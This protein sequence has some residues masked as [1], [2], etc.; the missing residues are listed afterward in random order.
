MLL[1]LLAG[2]AGARGRDPGLER[3][4]TARLAARSAEAVAAWRKATGAL[5]ARREREAEAGFREV[6]RLAPDFPDAL[7][8]LSYVVQG[9]DEALALARRA[10]KLEDTPV[11]LSALIRALLRKVQSSTG[12][13][14]ASEALALARQLVDREPDDPDAHTMMAEAA[15]TVQDRYLLERSVKALRRLA[16]DAMPTHYFAG[17]GAAMEEDWETAE[18]E[19]RRARQLGLP[20]EVADGILARIDDQTREWRYLKVIGFTAA[21]W[22]AGLVLLLLLGLVLSRMTLSAVERA[23]PEATAEPGG[24]VRVLRRVY[25]VVLAV[26]SLYFYV[27][28][29]M[30]LLLVLGAAGALFYAFWVI[31]RIPIKLVIIVA[32]GVL[33]TIWAM[34]K[35]PF[36]RRRDED[37]GQLLE[38]HAAPGLFAVLRDVAAKVG[39]RPVDAVYLVP[40]ATVAVLERGSLLRRMTG[41]SQRCLVLGLGVLEGMSD[42]QLKAILAHEYGHFS[43]KDTAGGDLALHVRTTIHGSAEAMAAGGAAAWYNPAWLFLN[44]FYRIYLRV[45]QGASRLQEVLADRWAAVT[46]GARAFADGLRHVIRRAITF[47]LQADREVSLAMNEDRPVRNL[48]R[49]TADELEPAPSTPGEGGEHYVP[50]TSVESLDEAI[51]LAYEEAMG[52]PGSAYDSHPAPRQ[53]IAW[54][55]RLQGAPDVPSDGAPAWSLMGDRELLEQA[56][57]AQVNEHLA[58]ARAYQEAV[59][60]QELQE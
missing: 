59:A 18:E 41:R 40:D 57:T 7:R 38:E 44:G 10:H 29:P 5:D 34:L 33:V 39:T 8:R 53:R 48:Y 6:L 58:L 51:E 11:N 30:V 16:P 22:A 17:I 54:V 37:P 21:G 28:I 32:I 45:S 12:A 4:I 56:M 1:S 27:S 36:I 49:L 42:N 35:S 13:T 31:G 9:A 23:S 25:A 46:Y 3:K 50:T 26:T 47:D 55:E 20:A 60:E 24:G 52:E 15:V 43:N 19:I 2:P 14:H